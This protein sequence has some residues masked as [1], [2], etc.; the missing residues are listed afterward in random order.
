MELRETF[1]H[2]MSMWS[3]QV[4]VSFTTTPGIFFNFVTG[5]SN[6]IATTSCP[7]IIM[8]IIIIL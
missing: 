4:S 2:T 1:L 3:V 8:H 7:I 5:V 6:Y